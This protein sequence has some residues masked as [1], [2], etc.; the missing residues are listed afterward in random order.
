MPQRQRKDFLI[1][2]LTV[3]SD[4]VAIE[5]AFLV[6]YWL[7]FFSPL[8]GLIP[9][10]L[11]VPEL[12]AYIE[13]S[14]VVIPAWLFLFQSRGMYQARRN[15]YFSDEF[16]AIVRV[17]FVG[18]LLVMAGAF[19]YREF[20]YS[21]IVFGLL[22][23]L[24]VAFISTGRFCVLK[25]EQW[26]YRKGNDIKHVVIV[27]TNETARRVFEAIV[28]HPS[29]GYVVIG[30]FSATG[31][32]GAMTKTKAKYL[33]VAS[34]VPSY[35]RLHQVEVVLVAL[36]YKEHPQLYE[37]V[38]DCEGLNAEIMMV[39][40]MVELMTSRVRIKDIEGIPFIRIKDVP[41]STWNQ[42]IKRSF[43]VTFS[44]LVLVLVSPVFVIISVLIKLDSEGPVFFSQ[45][46]VGVDGNSF[47]VLK[48]RTMRVHAERET[49][50]VWARKND[51]R[52][53]KVGRFLRRFSFDEL[54][55]LLNVWKGDMSIVGPR[56][57]RPHFVE[58]FKRAV[59]KY[60][61][62]HRVKTGMT[63][64]AQVN[65][66]RGSA[67][68]QERTKYDIYYIENWSLVFDLKIILKTIRAV[69]FGKDAY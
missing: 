67:P 30:Y 48:F 49:G 33:G 8:T 66:L 29:L 46:R 26:W 36:T 1:P 32:K 62:R 60:L 3:V 18:M 14:L 68:I 40:D 9:V 44:T 20:S 58:Q 52:A 23:I 21:R 59:P 19:F 17:V 24:G 55:Q 63:G 6:S 45:E 47:K 64:W 27:G 15:V 38:R 11:G 12:V 43:D 61:D 42:I 50:P 5:A 13:G 10:T 31:G 2:F 16:F 35:I 57:E 22:G 39:P 51:P 25:F 28:D 56:P 4:I 69:L 34:V 7:R 54:P 37:L 41:L 53:T 65:G